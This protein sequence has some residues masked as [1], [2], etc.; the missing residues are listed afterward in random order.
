MIYF[1]S[2]YLPRF[3]YA[4]CGLVSFDCAYRATKNE[5]VPLDAS[6]FWFLLDVI[7]MFGKIIFF[8]AVGI[9]LVIMGC[10]TALKQVKM[11]EFE[12]ST[13]EFRKSASEKTGN[14]SFIP[15]VAIGLMAL[16]LLFIQY[17]GRGF[18]F[19][20]RT[21]VIK[22]ESFNS[23]V[24]IDLTALNGAVMTGMACLVGIV[25]SNFYFNR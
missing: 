17:T 1:L 13:S 12:E 15:A 9:L 20:F 22:L 19:S 10:L 24:K 25:V 14:K 18:Y 11:E 8:V 4:L 23:D 5:E 16:I 3:F 21:I 2:P 6:V 7:F